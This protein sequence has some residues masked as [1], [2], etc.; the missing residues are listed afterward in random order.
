[1]LGV[2]GDFNFIGKHGNNHK[3][4][5]DKNLSLFRKGFCLCR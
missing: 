1:V 2:F 4:E 3:Q 5:S